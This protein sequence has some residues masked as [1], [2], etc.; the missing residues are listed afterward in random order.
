MIYATGTPDRAEKVRL[1]WRMQFN[2]K[3][4]FWLLLFCSVPAA[5]YG[6]RQSD[7]DR[8]CR[9]VFGTWQ[10]VDAQG[11]PIL[12]KGSPISEA[13]TRENCVIN[14]T[15]EPKQLGIVGPKGTLT[16]IYQRQGEKI[17][18]RIARPNCQRPVSFDDDENSFW[19]EMFMERIPDGSQPTVK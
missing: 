3:T 6:Y 12:W 10:R 17:Q 8:V 14:P 4:L 11:D 18:L 13:W 7:F 19:S 1:P 15:Q 5:W 2:L 9:A 16:G